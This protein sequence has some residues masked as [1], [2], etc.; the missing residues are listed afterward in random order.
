MRIDCKLLPNKKNLTCNR[1]MF[2][3]HHLPGPAGQIVKYKLNNKKQNKTP[4]KAIPWV[5]CRVLVRQDNGNSVVFV[6][7]RETGC[8]DYRFARDAE[9]TSRTSL[10]SLSKKHWHLYC[11]TFALRRCSD[12]QMIVLFTVEKKRRKRTDRKKDAQDV[13]GGWCQNSR[14]CGARPKKQK[15]L[16]TLLKRVQISFMRLWEIWS[17]YNERYIEISTG[18]VYTDPHSR[19]FSVTI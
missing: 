8:W 12:V 6:E 13:W 14:S 18:I 7:K 15:G 19:Y 3:Q 16:R 2:A 11:A 4:C 10:S 17:C 9:R 1:S 5:I